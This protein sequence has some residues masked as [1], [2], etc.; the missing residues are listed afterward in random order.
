MVQDLLRK[1]VF[2]ALPAMLCLNAAAQT[3]PV[4]EP[5]SAG[6]VFLSLEKYDIAVQY[7]EQAIAQNPRNAKAW[8]QAGFCM[9]KL[10]ATE[11][12]FRAYRKAIALEP[13]YADAHYSLGVSLLLS[14]QKCEA[15]HEL[16]ALKALDEEL[17]RRLQALMDWML[18]ADECLAPPPPDTA[19]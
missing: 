2:W 17:A 12:K 6:L 4:E 10:G 8:Y 13:N 11:E 19:I 5:Y 9:G 18:D 3:A 1:A 7:F 14:S 15:V 16:R